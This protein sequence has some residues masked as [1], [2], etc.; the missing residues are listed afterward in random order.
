MKLLSLSF[1]GAAALQVSMT[2]DV[3]HS[4]SGVIPSIKDYRV[5]MKTVV[6]DVFSV[7]NSEVALSSFVDKP[8]GHFGREDSHDY[9]FIRH[10]NFGATEDEVNKEIEKLR[11]HSGADYKENQLDAVRR[12][13]KQV[14][15][16]QAETTRWV[17]LLTDSLW[18]ERGD[19]TPA[20]FDVD[21]SD[22]NADRTATC[23]TNDYPGVEFVVQKAVEENVV[24]TFFVAGTIVTHYEKLCGEFEAAG[25]LC[26]AFDIGSVDDYTKGVEK[27]IKAHRLPKK[28]HRSVL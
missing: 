27:L 16:D 10:V 20:P 21:E 7:A 9:C 28:L 18:H 3:S 2:V 22:F 14:S 24:I 26:Y 4:V 15:W 13:I 8:V 11:Y 23:I 12:A 5:I 6:A 1:T 25:V 19:Y 17:Y